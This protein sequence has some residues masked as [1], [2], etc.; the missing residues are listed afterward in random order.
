MVE[1]DTC[2]VNP[3]RRETHATEYH[4]M[5]LDLIHSYKSSASSRNSSVL[6]LTPLKD[7]ARYLE[8]YFEHLA[9]IDYPK[10]LVSLGFMVSTYHNDTDINDTT[11][12]NTLSPLLD[13]IE[14]LLKSQAYK[15]ITILQEST[16]VHIPHAERHAANVQELRRKELAKSRNTLLTSTLSDESWVLWLDVDVIQYSPGLLKELI[17]LDKDVVAPNCFRKVRK[18][19]FGTK[20]EPYDRNN[21]IETTESRALQRNLEH[22]DILFEGYE[23]PTYRLSMTDLNQHDTLPLIPIDGVGA[24]FTLVKA[25]VHR[26]GINFPMYPTDHAIETEGFAK[27]AK[28]VGFSVFG[29]P[30]TIVYHD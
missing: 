6:I 13:H 11:L 15:R 7:A 27:W 21:W 16:K 25:T 10:E 2:P 19:P 30:H 22:D 29:A 14:P 4:F 12:D 9:K 1:N 26:L 3:P 24:T 5:N 20:T 8:G 17:Q 18:F 28:H 23:N